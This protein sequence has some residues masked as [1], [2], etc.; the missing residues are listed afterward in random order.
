VFH[1]DLLDQANEQ[2]LSTMSRQQYLDRGQEG[3]DSRE[4]LMFWINQVRTMGFLLFTALC[5][6]VK[7]YC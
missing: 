5:A 1:W 2:A 3:A 4:T 7:C 6:R